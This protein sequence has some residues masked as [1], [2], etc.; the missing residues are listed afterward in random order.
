MNPH[1]FGREVRQLRETRVCAQEALAERADLNRSCPGGI[2][3][4]DVVPSL[5]TM[6][7]LAGAPGLKRSGRVDRCETRLA[8]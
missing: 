7:W 6:A 3:R 5:N 8:A 4:G 1:H 2:E